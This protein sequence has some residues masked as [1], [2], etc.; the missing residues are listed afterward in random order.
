MKNELRQEHKEKIEEIISSMKCPKDFE[1]Y[2]SGFTV[3]GKVKDIG[4]ETFLECL[5]KDIS[6]CEFSLPFGERYFCRCPL[7]IYLSKILN[8]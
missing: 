6:V 3:L 8:K 2:K 7:R 1:C 5:E 4:M